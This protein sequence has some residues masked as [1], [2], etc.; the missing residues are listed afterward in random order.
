M[1]RVMTVGL[2]LFLRGL[3]APKDLWQCRVRLWVPYP[4]CSLGTSGQSGCR[5]PGYVYEFHT[6]WE[7]IACFSP[8]WQCDVKSQSLHV[9]PR[10]CAVARMLG[11]FQMMCDIYLRI[12]GTV[13]HYGVP[14]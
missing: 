1:T 7:N 14:A 11:Y 2:P 6:L 12:T 4:Q 13:C 5:T 9:H 10:C 8:S 3:P